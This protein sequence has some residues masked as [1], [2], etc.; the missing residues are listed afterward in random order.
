M[1][2]LIRFVKMQWH[3]QRWYKSIMIEVDIDQYKLGIKK[4]INKSID[5]YNNKVWRWKSGYIL[6]YL[7]IYPKM[8]RIKKILSIGW[9]YYHIENWASRMILCSLLI[10]W[11]NI[12]QQFL[13][14][15]DPSLIYNPDMIDILRKA[16][17]HEGCEGCAIN[18]INDLVV[19]DMTHCRN[20]ENPIHKLLAEEFHKKDESIS[21][22]ERRMNRIM[23]LAMMI[24]ISLLLGEHV[25]N[26]YPF[27][28][29]IIDC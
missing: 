21:L 18:N 4:K 24:G 26:C 10:Y 8:R 27:A 5:Y 13:E 17:L 16:V 3:A 28:Q 19:T 20:E 15:L 2:F 1:Y 14:V 23:P 25:I 6:K 9:S 7:D 29:A 22:E 12:P 11:A